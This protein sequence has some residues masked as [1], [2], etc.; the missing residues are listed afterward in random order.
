MPSGFH[1]MDV[2]GDCMSQGSPE[3]Q[4]QQNTYTH[5]TDTH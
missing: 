4:K 1:N 5:Y 3:K 2:T